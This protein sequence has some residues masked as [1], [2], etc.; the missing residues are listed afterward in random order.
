MVVGVS[1]FLCQSIL[2]GNYCRCFSSPHGNH[3]INRRTRSALFS[4]S[5]R[6]I[7]V[8]NRTLQV[9]CNGNDPKLERWCLQKS[10]VCIKRHREQSN[11]IK[12][13]FIH[14]KYG[15]CWRF[16]S[17]LRC[18]ISHVWKAGGH[19]ALYRAL[20]DIVCTGKAVKRQRAVP[21]NS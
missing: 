15:R 21:T 20:T 13:L 2:I 8:C 18:Y 10:A 5:E 12:S 19:D 17:S 6:A 14:R 1:L 7:R 3:D 9:S 16:L 4:L 11:T